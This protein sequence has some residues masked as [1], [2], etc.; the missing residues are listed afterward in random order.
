VKARSFLKRTVAVKIN[1]LKISGEI[2]DR[3]LLVWFIREIAGLTGTHVGCDTGHCGACTILMDGRTVKSCQIL[4]IQANNSA[5][6]TIEGL[7]G[8]GK[9]DILQQTFREEFA[10]QCGYCTPGM[11]LS[12]K[13]LLSRN[14]SPTK[15]EIARAIHGNLCR[16]EGYPAIIRAIE[17]A[18]N[19]ALE[20]RPEIKKEKEGATVSQ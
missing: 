10:V 4:T 2:E 15:E 13:F 17:K 1:G 18:A 12:A 9:P 8:G 16:C 11:I 3:M 19:N 6:T 5:I 14:Q 20:K 7:S